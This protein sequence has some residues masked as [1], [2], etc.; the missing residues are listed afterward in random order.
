MNILFI[1]N[2]EK[3]DLVYM[4][5]FFG[6]KLF[7]KN[8]AVHIMHDVD[9]TTCSKKIIKNKMNKHKSEYPLL[10]KLRQSPFYNVMKKQNYNEYNKSII[11][12]FLPTLDYGAGQ[13]SDTAR[14][15]YDQLLKE[16]SLV[17]ILGH[18]DAAKKIKFLR[19][20]N[21]SRK[22]YFNKKRQETMKIM[23]NHNNTVK[24]IDNITDSEY[25]SYIKSN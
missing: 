2:G 24:K 23:R 21:S 22:I 17:F 19:E 11:M 8:R 1:G 9:F 15:F 18:S 13:I 3:K 16:S 6:R 14:K 10:L 7:V 4:T 5:G 25:N 20:L 12:T